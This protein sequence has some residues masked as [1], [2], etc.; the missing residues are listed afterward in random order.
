MKLQAA[1]LALLLCA[2][3][4]LA[5]EERPAAEE[6]SLLGLLTMRPGME[7]SEADR[8]YLKAL[9]SMQQALMKTEMTGDASGDFARIMALHEQSAQEMAG[10]LLQQKDIDPDIRKLA[11]EMQE[12]QAKD[13]ARLQKWLE[14]HGK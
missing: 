12:H 10:V 6:D 1:A 9:Q 8:G 13:G 2:G 14:A 11:A 3:A 7:M 5:Q 4:A